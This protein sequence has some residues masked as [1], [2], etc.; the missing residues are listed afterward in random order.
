MRTE[1]KT[2]VCHGNDFEIRFWIGDLLSAIFH[3]AVG[4]DRNVAI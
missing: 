1:Q 2:H 3:P 4:F